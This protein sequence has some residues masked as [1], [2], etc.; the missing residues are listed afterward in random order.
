MADEKEAMNA[1]GFLASVVASLA[2]PAIVGSLLFLLRK[3]IAKHFSRLA[4]F[5]FPGGSLKFDDK[6]TATKA[7]AEEAMNEHASSRRIKSGPQSVR[8]SQS[9][10]PSDEAISTAASVDPEEAVIRSF[11]LVDR[12]L[13]KIFHHL[14]PK[15][16]FDDGS[17]FMVSLRSKNLISDSVWRWFVQLRQL[18][19]VAEH[20]R[21][22]TLRSKDAVGYY[23]QCVQF[24]NF[25]NV[26]CQSDLLNEANS[27]EHRSTGDETG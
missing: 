22:G 11:L 8:L 25:I 13:E 4:E 20:V 24:A 12:A 14:Y 23:R 5:T 16:E 3:D 15:E 1:L 27:H 21:P 9:I 7:T 6:L 19:N 2:W 18:R 17:L 10:F 26:L